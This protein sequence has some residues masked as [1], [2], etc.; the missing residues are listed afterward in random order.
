MWHFLLSN[1]A[2]PPEQPVHLAVVDDHG[3]HPLVF[4]CVRRDGCW[5]DIR[6]KRQVDVHPT[7]W[8][9]WAGD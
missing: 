8:R 7:H 2:V 9:A 6:R 5:I 4:P 1:D 3:F